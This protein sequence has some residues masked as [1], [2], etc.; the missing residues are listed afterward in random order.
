MRLLFDLIPADGDKPFRPVPQHRAV[1]LTMMV[2]DLAA[3]RLVSG[4]P[5]RRQD[6]ERFIIGRGIIA[7]ES[8]RRIR[9]VPLP[10][11]GFVKA[12]P[13]I[14]RIMVEIPHESP[15]AVADVEWALSGQALA[16]L[17]RVDEPSG[18]VV[19]ETLLRRSS[20]ERML[21]HY[22]VGGSARVWRS[23]TPVALPRPVTADGETRRHGGEQ[24]RLMR[25]LYAS[26]VDALRH[27]GFEPRALSIRVQREPFLPQ[28]R[29]SGSY[30]ASRFSPASLH[31]VEI[32]FPSAVTGP[33]IVG[34][35][36]FLGL[37]L[38]A[39]VRRPN[40]VHGFA[41]AAAMGKEPAGVAVARALRRAVMSRVQPLVAGS[42]LPA[43]F[44]GHQSDGSPSKSEHSHL[45][46]VFHPDDRRLLVIAPHLIDHREPTR[47][48]LDNLEVLD[49]AVA[50]FRELRAGPAGLLTLTPVVVNAGEDP[51]FA[52]S[53]RWETLT[54]YVCTRHLKETDA[55]A[56]LAAD[57]RHEC[58]RRGLPEPAVTVLAAC[59]V[60]GTGLTG[61]VRLDFRVAVRGPIVL[62][63][64]RHLGGGL[65]GG[66]AEIEPMLVP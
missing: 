40:D 7:R 53:R 18:E 62:G 48:E 54:R 56:A 35:G 51:L 45:T 47:E 58:R 28:G 52:R 66:L 61:S 32:T 8:H 12:D 33:V 41:V 64:D 20:D 2:R 34:D 13:A 15:F 44:S 46:F 16:P 3:K 38:L 50:G 39:P 11:I 19:G 57:V 63:R 9:F 21:T 65:F 26:V 29:L 43:F 4:L 31:H 36:R 1:H 59:G 27:A 25:H 42:S 10:S 17:D 30:A 22:G 24:A 55:H 23:I 5:A 60:P 14:R 37:G 49:R 6:V